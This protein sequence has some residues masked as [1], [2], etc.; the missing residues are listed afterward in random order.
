MSYQYL[1]YDES[2]DQNELSNKST[3]MPQL[4]LKDLYKYYQDQD[5]NKLLEDI[6][7]RKRK[8]L[9]EQIK[10]NQKLKYNNMKSRYNEQSYN[11]YETDNLKKNKSCPKLINNIS[12]NS[13]NS[14][15]N[16]YNYYLNKIKN[17]TYSYLIL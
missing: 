2:D 1:D 4:K 6:S 11:E 10:R 7:P 14:Q 8:K 16:N 5:T 12:N 15:F 9:L 13:N 17:K 3:K